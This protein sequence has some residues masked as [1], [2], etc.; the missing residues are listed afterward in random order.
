VADDA[1]FVEIKWAA[2]PLRGEKFEKA[3]TPV[4]EAALDYGASYWAFLRSNEG[5]LD[6]IQQAI[7]PTKLDFERYW[8]SEEVAAARAEVQGLYQVPILPTFHTIVG[9][10][11]V[12][13]GA[14]T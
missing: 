2:N 11:V 5:Q 3:W 9:T 10:G 13:V 7:F 8:Y 4:A 6:F 12:D 1:V 14:P